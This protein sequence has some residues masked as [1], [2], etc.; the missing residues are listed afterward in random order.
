[1]NK[2]QHKAYGIHSRIPLCCI[3]FFNNEWKIEYTRDT[4]YYRAV[5][6]A[7]WY[8]VPCPKCLATGHKV[9]IRWCIN[10]CGADHPQD[11]Q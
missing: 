2:Q 5:T 1:M 11:F 6:I 7:D 3:D 4:P 9:K 10:E 8:Y